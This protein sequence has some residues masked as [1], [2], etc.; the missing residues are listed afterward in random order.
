MYVLI[1]ISR[2]YIESETTGKR[3]SFLVQKKSLLRLEFTH[4][5]HTRVKST[6]MCVILIGNARIPHA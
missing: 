4:R 2:L 1:G 5:K 3:L 6:M